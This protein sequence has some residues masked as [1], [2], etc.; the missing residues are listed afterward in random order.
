[1]WGIVP[2][3]FSTPTGI[4]P[5]VTF[6]GGMFHPQD[7]PP[8][9]V[10][11]LSVFLF[12]SPPSAPRYPASYSICGLTSPTGF[13]NGRRLFCHPSARFWSPLFRECTPPLFLIRKKRLFFVSF[14]FFE[15]ENFFPLFESTSG[16]WEDPSFNSWVMDLRFFS[17][18]HLQLVFS[19]PPLSTNPSAGGFDQG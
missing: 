13:L 9:F 1:L 3:Q 10:L 18:R 4:H 5:C 17:F 14:S 6:Q 11:V 16:Y 19:P 2:R 7:P 12:F 15:E 8:E